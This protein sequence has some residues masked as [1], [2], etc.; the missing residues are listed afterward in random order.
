MLVRTILVRESI[1]E[2][3]DVLIILYKASLYKPFQARP[4][5]YALASH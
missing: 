5:A 3:R 4:T 1:L 2:L